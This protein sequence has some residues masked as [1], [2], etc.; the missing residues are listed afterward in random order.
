MRSSRAKSTSNFSPISQKDMRLVFFMWEFPDKQSCERRLKEHRE[1][2]IIVCPHWE[3]TEYYWKGNT[4]MNNS[5]PPLCYGFIKMH[6][7]AST[8]KN[9]SDV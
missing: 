2:L 1:A 9:F 3:C 5:P 7:Q 6:L 4:V 8:E